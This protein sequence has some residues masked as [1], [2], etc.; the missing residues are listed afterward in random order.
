MGNRVGSGRALKEKRKEIG[1]MEEKMRGGI[2]KT[3]ENGGERG[4]S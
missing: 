3:L 2:E 1:R 4:G